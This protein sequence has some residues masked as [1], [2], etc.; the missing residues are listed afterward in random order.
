V[1]GL[2]VATYKDSGVDVDL[3]NVASEIL[4]EAAKQTWRNREGL[5]GGIINPFDDFSGIRGFDVSGLPEGSIM[6]MGFDGVGTKM[7]LAER[8]GQHW[9][10][11]HDLFAMV[12]DDAV[13]RGGEPFVV[14]SVLDIR[15]LKDADGEPFIRE[16]TELANGYIAA[17]EAAGVA[18]INGEIAE[19]GAR[20]S[21][22]GEFNYN[23]SAGV[24]WIARKDRMITGD[25][26]QAGLSLV[27]LG[28]DGF[29][30]NGLSLIRK[31]LVESKGDKWHSNNPL[32]MDVLRPSVIYTKPML[33]MFGG[34]LGEPKARIIGAAHITGGGIPEK[35]GRMLKPSGLGADIYDP[36]GPC[37]AMAW[38]QKAGDVSDEEAYNTWNMGQGMI[39]AT[40]DPEKVI[41]IAKQHD[42]TSKVVGVVTEDPGIRI[43]SKG[44]YKYDKTLEF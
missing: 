43:K 18:V 20:I 27:G 11:A 8:R 25:K 37:T 41:S 29:R 26:I 42:I 13:I 9:T 24:I 38:L 32:L 30:S 44:H 23:W 10:I 14:G 12:C 31:I 1:R 3:G 33:E 5:F 15:S 36:F 35:L 40:P 7:E 28:E 19:L 22:Y 16:M 2:A 34:F 17:A 39:V 21:G 4:F 6:S